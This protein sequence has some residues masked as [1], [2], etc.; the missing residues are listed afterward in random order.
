MSLEP[1]IQLKSSELLELRELLLKEQNNICPICKNEVKSPVVD[2]QHKKRVKGSGLVRGVL[3][4]MCNVFLAKPE[5]NCTR[6]GVELKD[7]PEVLRNMAEY[8]EKEHLPFIHPSEKEKEK[9]V[10]KSNYNKLK[11][12]YSGKKKFPEYPKS[13]KLTKLL[14]E[15]FIEYDISPYN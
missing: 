11:R 3:C 12:L 1:P 14:E 10:S 7:L 5:N 15:L 2:H 13:S 4:R 6:Y 8:L 9:S